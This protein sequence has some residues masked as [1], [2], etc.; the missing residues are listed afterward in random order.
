ME[1]V[2]GVF[3][4][5]SRDSCYAVETGSP[6][7]TEPGWTTVAYQRLEPGYRS[8]SMRRTAASAK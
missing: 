5:R 8:W 4:V 3:A 7:A 6:T 2:Q 1:S